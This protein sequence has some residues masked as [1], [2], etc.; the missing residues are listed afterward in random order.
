MLHVLVQKNIQLAE[1]NKHFVNNL[2][3]IKDKV[4]KLDKSPAMQNEAGLRNAC[5]YFVNL[6]N[7]QNTLLDML[8]DALPKSR[9][10]SSVKMPV[11]LSLTG[12]VFAYLVVMLLRCCKWVLEDHA[13]TW[14]IS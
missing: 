11:I 8:N 3:G 14:T 1:A 7:E 6:V 5:L 12:L 2:Q 13:Y 9:P 4:G 10:V